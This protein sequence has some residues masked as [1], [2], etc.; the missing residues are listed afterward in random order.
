MKNFHKF[1]ILNALVYIV[2]FPVLS[3]DENKFPYKHLLTDEERS[4]AYMI[5]EYG[6]MCSTDSFRIKEKL[7]E[8][9]DGAFWI[10][11]Q[12]YLY[13][14]NADGKQ[15]ELK[16][17][18]WN[19][20]GWDDTTRYSCSYENSLLM[21]D[22]YQYW[23]GSEWL[24]DERYAY[25]YD[26][27]GY[28]FVSL[29]QMGD[30][31]TWNNYTRSINYRN[32][33]TH[34]IDS[35]FYQL[36]NVSEWEEYLKEFRFYN[37]LQKDSLILD[38]MWSGTGWG[39]FGKHLFTYDTSTSSY[40]NTYL[41]WSG[42]EWTN[43]FQYMNYYNVNNNYLGYTYQIWGDS[44]WVNQYRYLYEY[45]QNNNNTFAWY[46][47]YL[48]GYGWGNVTGSEITYDSSGLKIQ[49]IDQ[50]WDG[51]IWTNSFRWTYDYDLVTGIKNNAIHDNYVLYNNYPNPFNPTTKISW[52][53]P[54]ASWQTLKVYNALG[55]EVAMLVNE[56]RPAGRY[57]I[58]FDGRNLSSGVYFY[59]LHSGSFTDTKKFVLLR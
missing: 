12:K 18:N 15:T 23:N 47:I 6:H 19:G 49:Q 37:T 48:T 22:S 13:S 51:F 31:L 14:Y 43:S 11:C 44:V 2:S 38:Y 28:V 27:F 8:K 34:K 5:P 7:K 42:G 39:Y 16:I 50:T 45:D 54:I 55:G 32:N 26:G 52:Q 57:E 25:T 24:N 41:K 40:V 35:L 29:Y 4:D 46:Q 53:S 21:V 20:T 58:E 1:L 10:P 17:Q 33:S 59:R 36:W 30:S 3:Q 56:Y 9:W